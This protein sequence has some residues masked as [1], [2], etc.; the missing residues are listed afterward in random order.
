MY[1]IIKSDPSNPCRPSDDGRCAPTLR[2]RGLRRELHLGREETFYEALRQIIGV[3]VAKRVVEF[4]IGLQKM[5]VDIMEEPATAQAKEE[6]AHSLKERSTGT[7][8][9][10]NICPQPS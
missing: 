3:E 6:T 2:D 8:H 1:V 4:S 9:S 5:T 7:E 10:L